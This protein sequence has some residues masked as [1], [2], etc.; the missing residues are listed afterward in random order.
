MEI[1]T[2]LQPQDIHA[3]SHLVQTFSNLTKKIEEEEE[4]EE[5]F[6]DEEETKKL[7]VPMKESKKKSSSIDGEKKREVRLMKNRL[8]AALSRQR[9]KEFIGNLQKQLTRLTQENTNY[10]LQTSKLTTQQW[11]N[12]VIV[13][14]LEKDILR[15]VNENNE[16]RN[17]LKELGNSV[18]DIKKTHLEYNQDID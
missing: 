14:R 5:D 8:S 16:L 3:F 4:E 9:K 1:P 7:R 18:E 17:R 12:K 2:E 10:Q 6:T 13:E 15:L 11:E